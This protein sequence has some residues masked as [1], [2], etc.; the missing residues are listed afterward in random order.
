MVG[1]KESTE[2]PKLILTLDGETVNELTIKRKRVLV[3]R[4]V[5]N[6]LN[7]NSNFISRH[8]VMFARFGMTT[9]LMDM[10]STNGTFVNSRR[11]SNQVMVHDDIISLGNHRIKFVDAEAKDRSN[12]EGLNFDDTIMMKDLSD[13]RRML[14]GEHTELLPIPPEISETDTSTPRACRSARVSMYW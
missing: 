12:V 5:H 8:H 9:L 2:S 11:V 14:A 10:N 4:S 6:D 3:G 7:I 1:G 13:L